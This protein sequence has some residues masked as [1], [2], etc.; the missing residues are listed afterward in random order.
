M[1]FHDSFT[2]TAEAEISVAKRSTKLSHFSR[3]K[4]KYQTNGGHNFA[5]EILEISKW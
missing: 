4:I 1:S 3:Y 5:I 2:N